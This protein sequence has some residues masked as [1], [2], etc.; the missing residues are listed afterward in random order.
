M[1]ANDYEADACKNSDISCEA[2]PRMQIRLKRIYETASSDDG[3]RILVDR[4]WPRGLSKE[5]AKIDRWLREVAPSNALRRWFNHQPEKWAEFKRQYF[6]ELSVRDRVA[7]TIHQMASR[8]TVTLLFAA[9]D[10]R[11]NNAVALKEYV[12]RSNKSAGNIQATTE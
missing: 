1:A 11:L 6:E 3:V 8:E 2:M 7:R 9:T 10:S 4:L 12:I 5:R